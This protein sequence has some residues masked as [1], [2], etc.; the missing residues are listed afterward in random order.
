ME[1]WHAEIFKDN[2]SEKMKEGENEGKAS[3]PRF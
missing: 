2:K 3:N 1:R